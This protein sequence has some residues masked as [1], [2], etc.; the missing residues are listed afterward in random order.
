MRAGAVCRLRCRLVSNELESLLVAGGALLFIVAVWIAVVVLTRRQHRHATAAYTGMLATGFDIV[1][2]QHEAA[3]LSGQLEL[4]VVLGR[5]A[6]HFTESARLGPAQRLKA[7]YVL[8]RALSRVGRD[9][10]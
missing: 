7:H 4:A 10:E 8:G 5:K 6:V 3:L 2:K 1:I 9:D